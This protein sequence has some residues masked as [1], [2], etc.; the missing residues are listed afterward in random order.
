MNIYDVS[1]DVIARAYVSTHAGLPVMDIPFQP[2]SCYPCSRAEGNDTDVFGQTLADKRGM[3]AI[4]ARLENKS[5][6]FRGHEYH[7]FIADQ[8][9]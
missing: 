7:L 8:P 1:Y 5:D 6:T 4:S 2:F 9:G 3:N